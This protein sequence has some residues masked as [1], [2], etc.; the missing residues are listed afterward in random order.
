MKRYSLSRVASFDELKQAP[1]LS[2]DY[3]YPAGVPD[4][5]SAYAQLGYSDEA[6][7][8]HLWTEEPTTRAVEEGDLG[9]PCEDSC[10][11][12]FFCPMEGDGRYFNVE[13]N[14]NGCMYLGF[15]S[16]IDDLIRLVPDQKAIHPLICRE[17]WGWEIFYEIPYSFVRR[18]FPDFRVYPG[19]EMRANC[20]KCSDLTEPPHY[21]SWSPVLGE[22]FTFHRTEGFGTMIF[23]N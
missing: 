22:P 8:V 10:L 5:V 16:C 23:A 17:A 21:F 6:L 13:F 11:E 7:F 3:S 1:A 14:A 4:G 15:A 18:F 2:I 12:F 9:M 20:Y 19:K